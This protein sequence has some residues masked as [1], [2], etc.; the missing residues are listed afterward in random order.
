MC[1]A[2]QRRGDRRH[3]GIGC[4][5]VDCATGGGRRPG[6]GLSLQQANGWTPR[7]SQVCELL[8]AYQ[9][10]LDAIG[11]LPLVPM[12]L[13]RHADRGGLGRLR[14]LPRPRW[15]LRFFVVRHV[16]RALAGL[17]RR[18]S[19][20]A[21]LGST[22]DAEQ[23]D[24]EA[25][26]EFQQSLPPTRPR[27]YFTLLVVAT[28][29]L[30]RPIIDRVVTW[31]LELP[32]AGGLGRSRELL[33]RARVTVEKLGAALSADFTSV[34]Q[35]LD[36]LLNGGLL[37]VAVVTLGLAL[38][39][40]VVLR[41]FVPAFRLKRMLFNL[42]PEPEGHHRSA[43]APWSVSQAT[44]I[45]ERERRL[46]EE[47][48][49][50]APREFPFDLVVPALV[51]LVPLAWG[52]LSV[53]SGLIAPLV[54]DRVVFLGVAALLLIPALV[55]LSWLYQ[56]WQRRQAGRSGPYMPFEVRL[57]GGS[58]VAKVERP[59]GV[60]ILVFFLFLLGG[61]TLYASDRVF[62]VSEVLVAGFVFAWGLSLPVSYLWWYRVKREL[63]DLDRSYGTRES[64][65]RLVLSRVMATVGWLVTAVAFLAGSTAT[66]M[67][68]LLVLAPV[69][70]RTGRRIRRAQAR[71]GQP[72]TVRSAWMLAPGLLLHPLVVAYLQHE[73]NKVWA[74][75]GEPLDPWSAEASTEAKCSTR[76]TPWLRALPARTTQLPEG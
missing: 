9:G 37:Q 47:L 75:E 7:G 39:L 50:R 40:Y 45:Y 49:G 16:G 33:E 17:S 51:V 61:Y 19:A 10:I 46:F 36:A 26:R 11:D 32:Q 12:V 52:G 43:A 60:R 1:S 54:W 3:P 8:G 48:G 76:T 29:V 20:R 73:L 24:R 13:W 70:I 65:Y 66:V 59:F 57:R 14:Y 30:G 67:T 31:G 23:Q 38:S 27:I 74:V 41:P 18:Y 21:A 2:V 5:V 69:F 63:R 72:E 53:R 34:N 28:I 4:G 22:A 35:A 64:G 55:R 15:L 68:A 42:A 44:G 62:T 6:V 25:V 71:A 56:T 58:A